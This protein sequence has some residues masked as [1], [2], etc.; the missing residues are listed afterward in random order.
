MMSDS[1]IYDIVN[2]LNNPFVISRCE[3]HPIETRMDNAR[4]CQMFTFWR[5]IQDILESGA[6]E[7][8]SLRQRI[9]ELE[10]DRHRKTNTPQ[11]N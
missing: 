11:S 3:N 5:E 4:M 8:R 9:A 10:N 1:K 6:N 7:I 2:E